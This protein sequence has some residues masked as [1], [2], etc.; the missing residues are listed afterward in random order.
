MQKYVYIVVTDYG[1]ENDLEVFGSKER[2]KEFLEA[3]ME[4]II[5][6]GLITDP[7]DK[8]RKEFIKNGKERF[9][10]CEEYEYN[11]FFNVGYIRKK[12]IR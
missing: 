7:A 2:A 4:Q 11:T 1:E 9:V 12:L 5:Q 10:I 8:I 3:E 6:K